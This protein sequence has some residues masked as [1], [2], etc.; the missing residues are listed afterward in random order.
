MGPVAF[1][2][3][4][5]VSPCARARG[6]RAVVVGP[7]PPP[8]PA[9]QPVPEKTDGRPCRP[10]RRAKPKAERLL[11]A[12]RVVVTL[13]QKIDADTNPADNSG[14]QEDVMSG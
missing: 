7:K 5:Q 1:V 11:R 10:L 12:R 6:V 4:G 13:G 8:A 2:T 3:V 9:R 14:T